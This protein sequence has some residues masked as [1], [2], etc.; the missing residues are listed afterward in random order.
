M[1]PLHDFRPETRPCVWGCDSARTVSLPHKHR[2]MNRRLTG[3]PDQFKDEKEAEEKQSEEKEQRRHA[4]SSEGH[5]RNDDLV[6]VKM[7]QHSQRLSDSENE[8]PVPGRIPHRSAF[9]SKI[10][11]N[12]LT[13]LAW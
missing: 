13:S 5:V 10:G 12:S 2:G 6:N 8:E 3:R 7:C 1:A 4:D 9:V 11:T